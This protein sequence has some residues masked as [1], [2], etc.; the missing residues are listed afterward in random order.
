MS[1]H[2]RIRAHRRSARMQAFLR[3]KCFICRDD[4]GAGIPSTMLGCCTKFLYET[5]LLESL[6]YARARLHQ[7]DSVKFQPKCPSGYCT[8]PTV[9]YNH[10]EVCPSVPRGGHVHLLLSKSGIHLLLTLRL[11]LW[12]R[13]MKTLDH[14][15]G[16]TDLTGEKFEQNE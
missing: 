12:L 6:K 4:P 2:R 16:R 1:Q 7:E 5:C 8:T 15:S 3:T 11:S 13:S 14:Q 10:D 9:L